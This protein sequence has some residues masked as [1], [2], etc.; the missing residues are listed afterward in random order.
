MDLNGSRSNATLRWLDGKTIWLICFALVAVE[1]VLVLGLAGQGS[2][3][4]LGGDGHEYERYAANLVDHLAY[5]TAPTAPFQPSLFRTPGYPLFLAIFRL[6]TPNSLLVVRIAQFA[7][8]GLTAILVYRV[9]LFASS[10]WVALV[11][12]I[13]CATFLPLIWL[14]T[15]QLTEILATFL[16]VSVVLLIFIARGRSD[17]PG[18]ITRY[19][20]LGIAIGALALVRPEDALLVVPVAIGLFFSHRDTARIIRLRQAGVLLVGFVLVM[21]PWTI[22][23]AIVSGHFV[24]LGANSGQNLYV[25]AQQYAG[26]VSYAGT[27]AD[28]RLLYAPHGLFAQ[29]TGHTSPYAGPLGGA[30]IELA[31][32]TAIQSAAWR[33][34]KT[35]G[36][37]QIVRSV[38]SRIAHLWGTGD[39]PPP[40]RSFTTAAHRIAV[41]QWALIIALAAFGVLLSVRGRRF[42]LW[43]L[44]LFPAYTTLVHILFNAEARYTIPDRPFVIIFAS[45]G[46]IW[47][48][49]P[50][51]RNTIRVTT[52][53]ISAR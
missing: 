11:S 6:L 37:G 2:R 52:R 16:A 28:Y 45:I 25:S 51:C 21:A 48:V 30:R 24:P 47:L 9:S 34:F 13:M 12:A 8:L 22:R 32:N 53:T 3:G 26:R 41:L 43:P 46:L 42:D 50:V 31:A 35:L 10:R 1:A 4:V 39:F 17:R 36:I 5:S 19:G 15:Y 27:P 18:A 7:L 49:N 40:R 38:P 23:N 29:I 44:A 33:V 20:V 14:A